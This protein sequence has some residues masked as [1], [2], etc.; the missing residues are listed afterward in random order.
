MIWVITE[1]EDGL[2]FQVEHCSRH[3]FYSDS[4]LHNGGRGSVHEGEFH[5]QGLGNGG[6]L[7]L[8]CLF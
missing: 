2:S 6:V 3:T 7:F 8:L 4:G 5:R 1:I